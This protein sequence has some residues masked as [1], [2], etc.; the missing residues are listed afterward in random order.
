MAGTRA[1]KTRFHLVRAHNGSDLS[2]RV[3][4]C[5]DEIENVD[6][7]VLNTVYAVHGL[8]LTVGIT[9]QCSP[10]HAESLHKKLLETK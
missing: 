2:K 5:M 1:V 7:D 3:N 10:T 4:R 6:G 9:Y 8:E